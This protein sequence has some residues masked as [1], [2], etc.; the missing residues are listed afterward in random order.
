MP[1]L[2]SLA[3]LNTWAR[4]AAASYLIFYPAHLVADKNEQSDSN[5]STKRKKSASHCHYSFSGIL[6]R[7]VKANG[8]QDQYDADNREI[9]SV[10]LST[11]HVM[12]IA[13]AAASIPAIKD[14]NL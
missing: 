2:N 5:G 3:F 7:Q 10:H 6:A 11:L 8:S 12:L 1:M 4:T 14:S 13:K 9:D